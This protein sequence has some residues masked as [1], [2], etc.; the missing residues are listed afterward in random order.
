MRH[1]F[2]L[3]GIL[4][5]CAVAVPAQGQAPALTVRN[6]DKVIALSAEKLAGLPRHAIDARDEREMVKYDGVRL[7]DVLMQA[8]VTF[9]QTMRGPRLASYV[10]A[11]SPDGLRVVLA[12]A[13]ID[14]DFANRDAIVADRRNGSPLSPRDGPLQLIIPADTHH[15]RWVRNLNT[16]TVQ[17]A[18]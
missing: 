15:A 14:P 1:V 4:L 17:T 16:L 7:I 10:V 11:G 5:C 6:G 8:G 18:P 2:A 3:F 12:L 9:G 13:E